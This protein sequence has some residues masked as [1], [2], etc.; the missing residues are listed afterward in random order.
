MVKTT[1][2]PHT[3]SSVAGFLLREISPN[4]P[5]P[6]TPPLRPNIVQAVTSVPHS[7]CPTNAIRRNLW[8]S[9]QQMHFLPN[10]W[11]KGPIPENYAVKCAIESLLWRCQLFSLTK[12][13]KNTQKEDDF[14]AKAQFRLCRSW[15][16]IWM[17]DEETFLKNTEGSPN[18]DAQVMEKTGRRKHCRATRQCSNQ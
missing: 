1:L 5:L 4:L 6:V 13:A 11:H 8:Y 14:S 3:Q 12:F 18:F 9:M 10:H 17:R 7:Q 16:S 15:L 2:L